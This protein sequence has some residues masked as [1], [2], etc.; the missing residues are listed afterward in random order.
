MR[1]AIEVAFEDTAGAQVGTAIASVQNVAPGQD[2]RWEASS[3]R[4]IEGPFSCE[5]VDVDHSVSL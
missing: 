5:V 1:H 3:L 4:T 2:A